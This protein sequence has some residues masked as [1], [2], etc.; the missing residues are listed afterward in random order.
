MEIA[1]PQHRADLLGDAAHDAS[2]H[3]PPPRI[4]TEICLGKRPRYTGERCRLEGQFE[5]GR[6]PP[7]RNDAVFTETIGRIAGP[8]GIDAVHFADDG[9]GSETVDEHQIVGGAL[10]TGLHDRRKIGRIA[11]SQTASH[12]GSA[13]LEQMKEGTASPVL[14]GLSFVGPS[15]V[16]YFD[17]F[18]DIG[19][20]PKGSTLVNRMQRVE[21]DDA[22]GQP[23]PGS[24]GALTETGH[25]LTLGAADQTGLR[26]PVGQLVQSPLF[27]IPHSSSTA[28]NPVTLPDIRAFRTPR[29]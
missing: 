14:C 5:E 1:V 6:E 25:Q 29:R 24:D 28:A 2:A 10:V 4:A 20:P 22:T 7:Q 21:N 26:H 12:L 9:L 23:N 27:H 11:R 13:R 19:A 18:R 15:I 3:D 16:E 8:A 17:R